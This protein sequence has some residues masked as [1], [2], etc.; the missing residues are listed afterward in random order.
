MQ[1]KYNKKAMSQI[2]SVIDYYL[3]HFGVQPASN[4][5]HEIDEKVKTL[6][7]YPEIGFPEPLLRGNY[8]HYRATI[9]G[10][11]HKIIYYVRGNTLRIAAFWDMRMHPDHL[12]QLI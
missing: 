12:K 7:K 9:I 10:R 5:A 6:R 11:Y 2:S 3:A 4:L 8:I 1:V